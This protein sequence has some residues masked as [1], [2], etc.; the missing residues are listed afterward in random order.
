MP[1]KF[2]SN[3]ALQRKEN[4]NRTKDTNRIIERHKE[5]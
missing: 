3:S 2:G 1:M 4:K 5:K